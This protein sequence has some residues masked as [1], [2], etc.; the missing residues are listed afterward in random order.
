MM[1]LLL[2]LLMMMIWSDSTG[3]LVDDKHIWSSDELSPYLARHVDDV[4][5]PS[6][7]IPPI[8]R[9][10]LILDSP[11]VSCH[12][13]SSPPILLSYSLI[14]LVKERNASYGVCT[15]RVLNPKPVY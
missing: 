4:V 12:A 7:P 15:L 5:Y 11:D 6:H 1:L 8:H 14:P 9:S 2:L 10:A 13:R 3:E